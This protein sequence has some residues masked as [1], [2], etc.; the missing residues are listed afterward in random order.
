MRDFKQGISAALRGF[1]LAFGN[2]DV[3]KSYLK[4]V[5]SLLLITVTLDVGGIWGLWS[6]TGWDDTTAGWLVFVFVVA[7]IVGV[8]GILVATPVIAIFVM[9][10]LMPIFNE[11]PFLAG[12]RALDPRRAEQLVE[13]DNL[14]IPH[15]IRISLVRLLLFL[16]LSLAAFAVSF[17]PVAGQICGPILGAYFTSRALGWE[18][19]DPYFAFSNMDYDRQVEFLGRHHASVVGFGLPFALMFAIPLVGPLLFVLAQASAAT[20]VCEVLEAAP[21]VPAPAP[22][23]A[24]AG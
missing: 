2:A 23:P 17:I 10:I 7:R 6:A 22:V 8:L 5:L 19:L 9:N 3:R 13:G 12:V 24:P 4:V 15:Q 21:T 1:R 18:L 14:S 20:L 11:G 16:F